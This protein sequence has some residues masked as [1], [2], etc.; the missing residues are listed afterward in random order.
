MNSTTYEIEE[1]DS[2]IIAVAL[3]DGNYIAH[4]VLPHIHLQEHE[5][6][7]EEDPYTAYMIDLPVS[8]VI[9][10]TSRFQVDLNR[11][12]DKAIY[13]V[14]EDAWNL[15]VWKDGFPEILG[16]ALMEY[17]QEFYARISELIEIA[18]HKFGYFLILDIHSYNHR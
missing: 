11:P 1:I 12:P 9:V 7:R 5:R 15:K 14:P 17:Y 2:P 10:H 18:I 8:R 4:E 13:K 3:H 16:S 6:F